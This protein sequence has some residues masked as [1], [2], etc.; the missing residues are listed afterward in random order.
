MCV[1]ISEEEYLKKIAMEE[2][3]PKHFMAELNKNSKILPRN[4]W[5]VARNTWAVA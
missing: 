5:V 4:T 2:M 1:L 3:Y